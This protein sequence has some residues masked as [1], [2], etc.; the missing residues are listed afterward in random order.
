MLLII[1]YLASTTRAIRCQRSSLGTSCTPLSS[2]CTAAVSSHP[3]SSPKMAHMPSCA[4]APAPSPSKL[5][6]G[7]RSSLSASFSPA[8]MQM[9]TRQSTPPGLT[10]WHWHC[11]QAGH[12]QPRRSTDTEAGLVSDPLVSTPFTPGAARRTSRMCFFPTPQVV[13]ACPRPAAPSQS[14]Q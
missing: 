1:L 7:T 4:T 11:G 8:W 9:L 12:R 3:C 10:A 2:G 14:P 6:P 5:G 13:F